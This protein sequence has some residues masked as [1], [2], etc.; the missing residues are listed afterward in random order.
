[1]KKLFVLVL[2]ICMLVTGCASKQ[3]I[4]SSFFIPDFNQKIFDTNVEDIS[5]ANLNLQASA[6]FLYS[7]LCYEV[8]D[9]NMNIDYNFAGEALACFDATDT[10]IIFTR[11]MY[12]KVYPASTTKL[13]T[14]LTAL[15]YSDP[16][17]LVTIEEDNCG[18]TT[19]GAQLCG[20]K[21]GDKLTIDQLLHCLMIYSGNDAG[22][23]IAKA[24]CGSEEKFVELMNSEASKIG[25]INTHFANA[26]GLHNVN[27]YTTAYDMYL[28][29]N[30]CLKN[31]TLKDIIKCTSY[32]C[33]YS[34]IY[35]ES[36][37]LEMQATNLYYAGQKTPPEGV[38]ILGGKTGVTAT[39][40]YC[41]VIAS[42]NENGKLFIT[43]VFKSQSYDTLYADM[44]QLLELIKGR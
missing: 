3:T 25:C 31:K 28:I 43:E 27:H 1:M 39:A 15:K 24:I 21:K 37:S 32:T 5:L 29:F 2:I 17:T 7:D 36:K 9:V 13:L 26:H 41:L 12:Q 10:K 38:Y 6:D 4:T 22:V 8:N 42:E 11:N 35:G 14:A 20:F 34:N 30:E 33:E 44:N 16:D 23:A 18:I 40:G 19:P